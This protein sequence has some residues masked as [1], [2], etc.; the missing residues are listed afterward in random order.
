MEELRVKYHAL[1][2][3]EEIITGEEIEEVDTAV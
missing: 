3:K 1:I 2:P